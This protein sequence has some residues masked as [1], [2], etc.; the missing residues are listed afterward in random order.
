[1]KTG[2][3]ISREKRKQREQDKNITQGLGLIFAS[4]AFFADKYMFDIGVYLWSIALIKLCTN[5]RF[6]QYSG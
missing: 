3:F 1:M 6:M 4:F 5:R 2:V